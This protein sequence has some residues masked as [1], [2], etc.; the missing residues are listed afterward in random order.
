MPVSG[1]S[2]VVCRFLAVII[3]KLELELEQFYFVARAD[4]Q[5]TRPV[6]TQLAC[7]GAP[8]VNWVWLDSHAV[9]RLAAETGL[10]DCPQD[11]SSENG[12]RPRADLAIP[13]SLEVRQNMLVKWVPV[14]VA[15]YSAR[16]GGKTVL[17]HPQ[18]TPLQ[19]I[20]I[21]SA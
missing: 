5:T 19:E 20:T 2:L 12:A 18:C 15:N 6:P 7:L 9:T 13:S 4:I 17:L 3:N 16:L 21:T 10:L 14:P 11:K 8:P 1:P